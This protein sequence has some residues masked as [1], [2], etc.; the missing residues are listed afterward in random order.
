MPIKRIAGRVSV[1]PGTVHAWTRDIELTPE[2]RRRNQFGPRGPQ[3]PEHVAARAATWR[4]TNQ[5]RRLC[6]QLEGRI[7]A[8]EVEALHLAGCMLYWAEGAKARNTL[9]FANSDLNMVKLFCRFLRECLDVPGERITLR[10]NVYTGNGISLREIENHWLRAL[11]L[12]RSCLRGHTINHTP[13][14][15]SGN[16]K[17]RLPYGVAQI[18]VLKSTHLVQ[19][20]LGAIQEYGA[21]N[22][23]G[24]LDGQP[25]KS[26]PR[27][28]R[29][30][31]SRSN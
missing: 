6:A 3:N 14:S 25:R 9:N 27:H 20:V 13:T 21:F 24:W 10:L 23:P 5:N 28:K 30:R 19:H 15:S 18:R 26:N 22:E 7:R 4:K 16:K 1:S 11:D 2:Q 12:P 29:P 8:H 31:S 17:N